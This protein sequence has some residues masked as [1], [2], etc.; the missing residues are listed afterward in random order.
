MFVL[1]MGH[2]RGIS[3]ALEKMQVPFG[4]WS[5]T[6]PVNKLKTNHI[7][8]APFENSKEPALM[9]IRGLPAITHIIAGTEESVVP[10]SKLRL[11]TGARRNNH[12]TVVRCAD[13]LKMKEYLFEKEIPMTDFLNSKNN[14]SAEATFERL[15]S[16][17]ISKKRLSSGGRALER[18]KDKK[19][20]EDNQVTG[21]I[22]EKAIT[23]TEGSIE[24]FVLNGEILFTSITRYAELGSINIVPGD[25]PDYVLNEIKELNQKVLKA[26]RL[27]FG[28]TH[29]EFYVTKDGVLFGEV[30]NRPPGGYIMDCIKLANDFS[31]WE[32]MVEVELGMTPNFDLCAG[33]YAAS[34][35][36]PKT[37]GVVKSI[38]GEEAIR[39]LDAFHKMKLKIEIGNTVSARSG[40]DDIGHVLFVAENQGKLHSD[41]ESFQRLFQL[42]IAE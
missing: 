21:R 3:K 17:V 39:K 22:F 10:A 4:V 2:R 16:P 35:V 30:A 12:T 6:A 29:L 20:L 32:K 26:L 19:A 34:I 13:K 36:I 42:E 38:K 37:K 40:L 8:T 9:A 33:R 25:Y 41:L 1:I 11:W 28:I 5:P 31:P 14:L 27:D 23:G 15:G 18:I 24:S 7:I